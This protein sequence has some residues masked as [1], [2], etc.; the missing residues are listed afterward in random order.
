MTH[1]PPILGRIVSHHPA[2]RMTLSIDDDEDADDEA[3]EVQT[4]ELFRTLFLRGHPKIQT[5]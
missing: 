5:K 2:L 1:Y 3:T 4:I